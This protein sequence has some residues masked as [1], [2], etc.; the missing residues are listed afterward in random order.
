[1]TAYP[2]DFSKLASPLVLAKAYP[3]LCACGL[4]YID[5]WPFG[6]STLA[7]YHPGMMAQFTQDQ[8]LPKHDMVHRELD[9]L[10]GCNDLVSMEGGEWKR[11][12]AIFNPGFS[13]KNLTALLP[14]FLEEIQVLKEILEE[15]AKSGEILK[16]E[17]VV[18]RA[19]VDVICRAAL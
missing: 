12:R 7:V 4:F 8:S 11:W 18:Q 16:L 15:A 14:A 10:T 19:T 2:G 17:D 13:A 3:E 9:P 5:T 6:G 1:M